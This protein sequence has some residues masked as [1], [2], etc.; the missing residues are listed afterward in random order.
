MNLFK[1]LKIVDLSQY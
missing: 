1:D